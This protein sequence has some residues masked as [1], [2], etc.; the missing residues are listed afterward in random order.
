M[1][2]KKIPNAHTLLAKPPRSRKGKL[3]ILEDPPTKLLVFSLVF[4]RSTGLGG[5][6]EA[7]GGSSDSPAGCKY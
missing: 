1:E 3:L 2:K 5:G 6:E 4:F 7:Q